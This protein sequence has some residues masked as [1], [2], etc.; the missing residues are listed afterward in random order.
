MVETDGWR[1]HGLRR[2]FEDDRALD[3]RRQAAGWT[4][5]RFTYRQVVHETL[6]V[7]VR[8]AQVLALCR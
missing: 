8:I 1:V 6:L 2:A 7:T 4:T 5:L 3:A